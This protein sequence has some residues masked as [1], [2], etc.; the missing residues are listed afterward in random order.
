MPVNIGIKVAV[1]TNITLY[2]INVLIS[3]LDDFVEQCQVVLSSDEIVISKIAQAMNIK[4]YK[5]DINI[6]YNELKDILDL[7]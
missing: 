2:S 1:Y 5:P 7:F 3:K 6:E 4:H